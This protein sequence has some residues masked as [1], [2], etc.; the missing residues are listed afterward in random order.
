MRV[1]VDICRAYTNHKQNDKN[2]E[3]NARDK[4]DENNVSD[5][6]VN[7][8]PLNPTTRVAKKAGLTN[9]PRIQPSNLLL[10]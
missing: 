4:S 10:N 5:K 9:F 3:K 7:E 2:E 6:L 8:T 1:A